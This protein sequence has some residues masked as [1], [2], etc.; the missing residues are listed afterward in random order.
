MRNKLL[1][2]ITAATILL[3][4]S[5]VSGCANTTI[6][7]RG[8]FS[9][10]VAGAVGRSCEGATVIYCTPNLATTVCAAVQS[11]VQFFNKEHPSAPLFIFGGV[12]PLP[13]DADSIDASH[14]FVT[15]AE[16]MLIIS[17]RGHN[18]KDQ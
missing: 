8:P 17:Q 12:R 15:P 6:A 14:M 1:F 10:S 11:G 5:T 3:I 2:I 9:H 4:A 13:T 18:I 16:R 7:A